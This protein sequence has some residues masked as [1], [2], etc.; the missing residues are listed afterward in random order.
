MSSRS[1]TV[2]ST[3]AI[4]DTPSEDESVLMRAT[5]H[6]LIESISANTRGHALQTAAGAAVAA[7]VDPAHAAGAPSAEEGATAS[8]CGLVADDRG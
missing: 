2:P 6:H 3:S 4:R 5:P 1:T 7:E 8:D